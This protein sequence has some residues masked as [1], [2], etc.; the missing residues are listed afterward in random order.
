MSDLGQKSRIARLVHYAGRVQG[1]GFRATAVSLARGFAV[2]GWVRNL[3]DGRVALLVEGD[4]A[5][6][7]RFLRAVR[8]HWG[9]YIADEQIT[10][11]EPTGRPAGLQVV[12]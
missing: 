4:A 5:E 6:V 12:R 11:A 9:S 8:E 1:V 10:Q 7:E 3:S 2:G